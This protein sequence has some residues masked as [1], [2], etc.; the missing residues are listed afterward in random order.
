M[1][2]RIHRNFGEG[3]PQRGPAFQEAARHGNRQVSVAGGVG[4]SQA[5]RHVRGFLVRG[6]FYDHLNVWNLV[7]ETFGD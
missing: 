4:S 2:L 5:C 7:Q 3:Q 1:G 6:I